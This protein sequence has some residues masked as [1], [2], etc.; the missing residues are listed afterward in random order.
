MVLMNL[1]A[2]KVGNADVEKVLV[3]TMWEGVSGMNGERS[4]NTHRCVCG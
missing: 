2:G 3:D 1:I 4:I